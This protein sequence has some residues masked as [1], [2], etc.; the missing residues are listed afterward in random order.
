MNRLKTREVVFAGLLIG[1]YVILNYW[2]SIPLTPTL[3]I[4]FGFLPLSFMSMLI[5]P[6]F[7]GIG[8]ALGDV[9][10][11]MSFPQGPF[12]FGFTVSAFVTGIIYGLILYKKPKTI[13]RILAAVACVTLLVDF[14]LNTYWLTLLYGDGFF[15]LLPGRI[16]KGLAMVPV[17]VAVIYTVWRYAGAMIEK[18]YIDRM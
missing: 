2:L 6:L 12:F 11:A 10:G 1:M 7:S 8:A 14:G 5:G 15:V 18:R 16:I 17:Q 3:I 4:K 13:L 9:I